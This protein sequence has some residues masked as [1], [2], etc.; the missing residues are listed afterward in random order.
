M[1]GRPTQVALGLPVFPRHY[2]FD[3]AEIGRREYIERVYQSLN[4]A[5]DAMCETQRAAAVDAAYEAF[6][7]NAV[8][9]NEEPGLVIDASKGVANVI[10]G[11]ALSMGPRRT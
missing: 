5:G 11:F 2:V 6:R 8:V 9:Y 7:H 1:L 3:I 4:E 10:A